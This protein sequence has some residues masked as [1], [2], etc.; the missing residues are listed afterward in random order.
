MRGQLKSMGAMFDWSREV[1]T[2]SPDY[3]KWTQW[4][5]LQ[6][7]KHD[8]AYKKKAAVWWCPKDQTVLANE[9]VVDGS[10]SA[11]TAPSRS[12]TWSSGSSAS[13]STPRSCW[14]SQSSEW[15][16]QIASM[17]RNW[18]GRSEGAELRSG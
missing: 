15:S 6:L 13:R 11:A 9:Q 5:F 14:T 18:I 2:A 10:A 17:Q 7:L 12:A 4:W 16:E 8:L 3:Y 1:T